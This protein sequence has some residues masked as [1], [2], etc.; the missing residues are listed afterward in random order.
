MC[1]HGCTC[2]EVLLINVTFSDL[3]TVLRDGG[4]SAVGIGVGRG[5]GRVVEAAQIA[6]QCPLLGDAKIGG[7]SGMLVDIT[8][9]E[10]TPW[11]HWDLAKLLVRSL[12]DE[13]VVSFGDTPAPSMREEARVTLIATGTGPRAA[14]PTRVAPVHHF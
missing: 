9:D 4:R 5:Q 14:A 6:L 11:E 10:I 13:V 8:G 3:R 2:A 7:A 12:N 1:G